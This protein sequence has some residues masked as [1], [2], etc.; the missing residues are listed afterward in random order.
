[1]EIAVAALYRCP[2][3]AVELLLTRRPAGVH[4]AGGWELPGGKIEPGETPRDALRRELT[5]EIGLAPAGLEPLLVTEHAYPGRRLRLHAMI[6]RVDPGAAVRDLDVAG[7][8][9]VPL[10]E[11]STYRLPAAN[12][13]ITRAILERL[14]E[15]SR[16]PSPPPP[17]STSAGA[18]C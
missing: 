13:P 11:L 5:E 17:S 14:P 1:M 6:G 12:G 15:G 16:Q 8:R 3:G 10:A 4:L 7:H 9:W 18:G 2:N